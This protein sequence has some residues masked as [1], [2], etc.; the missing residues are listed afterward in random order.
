MS[1]KQTR[2]RYRLF[3][4][5]QL[6]STA[7]INATMLKTAR[8]WLDEHGF[9]EVDVPH[10]VNATGSCELIST[11]F[12]LKYFD[13]TAYLSQTG[14]LYLEALVPFLGGKV[15][16]YGSSFRAE[17]KVDDRH[18]TE[19]SLLEL[20][21]EGD[22]ELLLGTIEEVFT[23]MVT[24]VGVKEL[25]HPF[26]RVRY[27]DAIEILG[28]SF[29]M[30][31]TSLDEQKLVKDNDNQPMFITHYPKELKYFNMRAN[32]ND[33]RIVNSADFLLPYG[34]ESAG[35]AEREY[36]PIKLRQRLYES[37]MW[38]QFIA[39]GGDKEAFDWYL[40]AYHNYRYNLH[41]GF[42]M[43]MNR[44]TKYVLKLDD[45][46]ETAIYPTNSETLY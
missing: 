40:D 8:H 26:N 13:K 20:E 42:G 34:G 38:T 24:S 28:L 27:E 16:T 22:F 32:D 39:E 2:D 25:K 31:T 3:N 41:S 7:I 33:P 19:F 23:A 1:L 18:L 37:G 14:Q 17:P 21:F 29:G 45:I 6:K 43:G 4:T 5:K 35:C 30:D 44:V 10:I 9:L 12:P 15:Y 36:N 11:L 46:R